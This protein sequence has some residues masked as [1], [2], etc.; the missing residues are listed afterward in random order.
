[1]PDE[2]LEATDTPQAPNE[3]SVEAESLEPEQETYSAEYVRELRA[4]SAARRVKAR[5]I[6][7]AND[8][9]LR[10]YAA[11]D[12]RLVD[13]GELVMTDALLDDD[14]LIDPAKVT[15]AIGELL[16]AKPYLASLRNVQPIAQGVTTTP[17]QPQGLFDLIRERL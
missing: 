14:G 12:G 9:L 4:E 5:K 16:Q 1:M 11:T 7:D 15:D 17:P 8:R 2:P 6:D 13:P 10:A 3:A